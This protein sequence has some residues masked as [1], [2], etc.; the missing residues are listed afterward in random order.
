MQLRV[1]TTITT[2]IDVDT[3]EPEHSVVIDAEAGTPES[4]ARA[5]A[6]GAARSLLKSLGEG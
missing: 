4:V 6:A 1:V 3:F 5:A 2:L